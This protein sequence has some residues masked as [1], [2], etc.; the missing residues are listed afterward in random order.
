MDTSTTKTIKTAAS[1]FE[2]PQKLGILQ[3]VEYMPEKQCTF[4][5]CF[6]EGVLTAEGCRKGVCVRYRVWVRSKDKRRWEA[7]ERWEKNEDIGGCLRQAT[8][9]ALWELADRFDVG[10]WYEYRRACYGCGYM[11]LAD[12]GIAVNG[13]KL[14][15]PYCRT[16]DECIRQILEDYRRIVERLK[17]PPMRADDASEFLKQYPELEVFGVE[18]VKAW[19]PYARERMA[20][21]AEIL[22]KH[23]KLKEIIEKVGIKE[24]PYIIEIFVAPDGEA[25]IAVNVDVYC[26]SDRIRKMSLDYVGMIK[27]RGLMAFVKKKEFVKVV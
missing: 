25:C 12:C 11:E 18:W 26:I 8:A 3:Q 5:I 4:G 7:R 19:M 21:I 14:G 2:L 1:V 15:R 20:Q 13:I 6:Y 24:N 27:P 23:A 17:E 22:R 9:D 16:A 10:V